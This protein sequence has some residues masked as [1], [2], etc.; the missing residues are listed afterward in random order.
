MQ[1][2]IIE[3]VMGAVVLIVA[4]FFLFLAYETTDLSRNTSDTQLTA[5]FGAVDGLILGSDVRI[6][7]V[8][9]GTVVDQ[10]I[11]PE[12]YEA[13]VTM[14]LE[15]GL[16]IPEDSK[17]SVASEGLLGGLY[18]RVEPGRSDVL[19]QDGGQ[20]TETQDVVALED[21]LGRAIFL[22]TEE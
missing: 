16:R 4:G 20:F 13:V 8:K 15:E 18:L 14:S 10:S 6:A 19:L 3:T 22:I 2:S 5:R 17:V 1:R 12:L 9:V 7:G 21:L 11:D